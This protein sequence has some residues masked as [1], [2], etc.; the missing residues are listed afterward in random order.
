MHRLRSLQ[1]NWCPAFAFWTAQL[2]A[3]H[4]KLRSRYGSEPTTA[5]TAPS[6]A[7]KL[8][9][10]TLITANFSLPFLVLALLFSTFKT[11]TIL[12]SGLVSKITV[13]QLDP[14]ARAEYCRSTGT[15]CHNNHP[16]GLHQQVA[17]AGAQSSHPAGAQSSQQRKNHDDPNLPHDACVPRGVCGCA[18]LA[19]A[20]PRLPCLKPP[21]GSSYAGGSGLAGSRLLWQWAADDPMRAPF[22]LPP[23]TGLPLEAKAGEGRHVPRCH[24]PDVIRGHF[25]A[26]TSHRSESAT[27]CLRITLRVRRGWEYTAASGRLRPDPAPVDRHLDPAVHRVPG[28]R[29]AP[30]VE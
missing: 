24:S 10:R 5:S 18:R 28:V 13:Y 19:D 12:S 6:V 17:P 20:P 22:I 30:R 15:N 11:V 8:G 1:S 23:N 7:A 21:G 3:F 27:K 29:S 16:C 9:K 25:S 2:T 26:S 14:V 4:P